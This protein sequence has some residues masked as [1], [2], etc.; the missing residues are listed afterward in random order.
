MSDEDVNIPET[1][2]GLL[3][4]YETVRTKYINN[5][6]EDLFELEREKILFNTITDLTLKNKKIEIPII[7]EYLTIKYKDKIKNICPASWFITLADD[8]LS[9]ANSKFYIDRLFEIKEEKKLQKILETAQDQK[10]TTDEIE[11][12]LKK[13]IKPKFKY[14][15][16]K[17]LSLLTSQAIDKAAQKGELY[18]GASLGIKSIDNML[19]GFKPGELIIVGARPSVGKT[20]LG[21]QSALHMTMEKKLSVAFFSL[22]MSAPSLGIR[23]LSMCTG[24]N[25]RKLM[26]NPQIEDIEKATK[27]LETIYKSKLYI[28]T[29]G[30]KTLNI[31]KMCYELKKQKNL[32]AVIVD[33]IQLITPVNTRSTRT[34]QVSQ[35][36]R[37]LKLIAEEVEI[38]IIALSQVR[39]E[40]DQEKRAPRL[41]DLRESGSLEQDSDVVLL[42]HRERNS[43][44]G[45]LSEE[46][47]LIISKNRHGETGGILVHFNPDRVRFEEK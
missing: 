10:W 46:G 9:D 43:I 28:A 15:N 40:S 44:S 25:Q 5:I 39:R 2:L 23:L 36:S 11:S 47:T 45:D 34:E 31:R 26:Y 21:L 3:M 38:P 19:G 8:I 29:T 35:I 33:Y 6:S 37:D 20:A 22:E 12:A 27:V 17:E 14:I 41:S 16:A 24:I 18:I 7:N 42:L 30:I 1:V 13:I 32:D 4:K